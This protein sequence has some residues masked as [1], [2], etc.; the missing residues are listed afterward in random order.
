MTA[1]SQN[2]V[3]LFSQ[4]ALVIGSM[5]G[6]GIFSWRVAVGGMRMLAPVFQSRACARARF[7][8]YPGF[9]SA[10]FTA[11]SIRRERSR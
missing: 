7:G 6:T 11:L 4:S 10:V 5:T 3:S 2:R 9:F 1:S 8:K